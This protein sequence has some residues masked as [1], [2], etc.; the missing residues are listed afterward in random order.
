MRDEF[1]NQAWK[2]MR[3]TFS[4]Y[5]KSDKVSMYVLL[6]FFLVFALGFYFSLP[7]GELLW[8][9]LDFVTI[10]FLLGGY[11]LSFDALTASL[12]ENKLIREQL[13]K[14]R[15]KRVSGLD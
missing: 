9:L 3:Q 5:G 4:S 15:E 12:K 1:R 10:G 7:A 13:E 14:Q 8:R 11:L 6:G 2:A